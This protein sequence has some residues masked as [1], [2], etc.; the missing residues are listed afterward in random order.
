MDAAISTAYL[1]E[2]SVQA[3]RDIRALGMALVRYSVF[4]LASTL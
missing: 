4:I 3:L 2:I 1:G